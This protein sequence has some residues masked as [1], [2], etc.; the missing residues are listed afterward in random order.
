M[1]T[2]GTGDAV[3]ALKAGI[4]EIADILVVNKS[5]LDG[6]EQTVNDLR[7]SLRWRP[8]N[9]EKTEIV[10][11]VASTGQGIEELATAI[12]RLRSSA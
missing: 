4:L 9:S 6:V 1:N 5:D 11:T 3:Q 2:P 8:S 10:Q 12:D 7:E